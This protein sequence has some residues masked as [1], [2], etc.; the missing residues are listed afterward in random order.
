MEEKL[1]EYE[2][3][4]EE[5]DG[6]L[7]DPD[8]VNRIDDVGELHQERSQ[9]EDIVEEYRAFKEM[10]SDLEEARSLMEDS[11][12]DAELQE[13]AEQE[14]QELQEKCESQKETLEDLLLAQQ[15][16]NLEESCVVEIR[17]GA[18]GEEASLFVADLF[19]MYRRYINDHSWDMEIMDATETDA[20]GY[21]NVT[22]SVEGEEAFLNFRFEGGTHR[23]QRVPETE[24]SGRIHT[25]TATVAVLPEPEEVDIELNEDDIQFSAMR[26]SGPGGQSVNKNATKVRL[27]HEPS[28]MSVECQTEKSQHQNRKIAMRLLK[29]RLHQR[30][31]EKKQKRRRNMRKN[32]IGSGE[33]SEKIRTYNFPQNRVTD[34][35]IELT[36][37]N[38]EEFLEGKLEEHQEELRKENRR[39]R[40]ENLSSSRDS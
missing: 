39:K 6:I 20:G 9:I 4:L 15:D 29:T 25:S 28:G 21:R 14:H 10:K 19:E 16:R 23:V 3:R 18:G 11:D 12:A 27:V 8:K 26:S 5:I 31:K 37:Y 22:F 38:L 17:A 32:Q 40:L 1:Q 13:L 7:Q 35:R 2:E 30:E 36:T 24:S 34:H 33:R